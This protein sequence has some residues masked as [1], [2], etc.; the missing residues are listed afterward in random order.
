[1]KPYA[2]EESRLRAVISKNFADHMPVFEIALHT[3]ISAERA[4]CSRMV[5]RGPKAQLREFAKDEERKGASHSPECGRFH[6][7]QGATEVT[8]EMAQFLLISKGRPCMD[9]NT[10]L[11]RQSRKLAFET[12]L[13]TVAAHIRK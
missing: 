1:M 6:C 13:G 2:D 5:P 9:T 7:V 4:V 10:G 3:G 12:S 8:P 11:I